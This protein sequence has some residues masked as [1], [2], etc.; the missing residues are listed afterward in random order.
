MRPVFKIIIFY[1]IFFFVFWNIIYYSNSGVENWFEAKILTA[2]FTILSTMALGFVFVYVV[3]ISAKL[4][5]VLDKI[6]TV[7]DPRKN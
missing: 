6:K 1:E 5:G 4:T 3:Y 2:I 7:K